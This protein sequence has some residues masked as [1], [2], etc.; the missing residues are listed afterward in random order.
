MFNLV[1][2]FE[3]TIATYFG[4]SYAVATDCCTHAIELCLRHTKVF[5]VTCPTRTYISIPFTLKK[6]NL[7]WKFEEKEWSEYY[8]LGNTNIIDA[9]V[10]WREKSFIPG[11]LMCL[12]FQNKKHLNLVRGGM[13]L[14][15]N[16]EDYKAL[17]RMSYDGRDLS[18]PWREQNITSI[19]YHYYMTP[20][21]AKEG[22]E[23]F[24]KVRDLAPKKWSHTDYPYLPMMDVFKYD[25]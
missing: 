11:T 21:T 1:T 12:S 13:I 7:N 20:E 19:G 9:A 22:I 2:E 17:K 8:F 3:N 23:K 18:L 5:S 14:C 15:D 25:E 16:Q 4:S 10:L 24:N 6:L